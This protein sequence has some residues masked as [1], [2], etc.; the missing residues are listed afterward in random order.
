MS[1]SSLRTVLATALLFTLTAPFVVKAQDRADFPAAMD[2]F[3]RRAMERTEAVPGLA[4]AVVDGAGPIHVAGFGV[5][6]VGTGA[7]VTADTRFYIAS[8][9]KSF[10]ALAVSA[11]AARGQ[12]DLDAPVATWS[13]GSGVPTEI[14]GRTTLSD[15]LSHRS[16]VENGPIAFRTAYSGDWTPEILWR[17]T[18]ETAPGEVP[19]GTFD[20][21]NSGYNL[22]TILIERQWGRDWR[23][24]VRD[25][26]LTPLGMSRTTALV[27][28]ARAQGETVAAGH[29]GRVPGR[30][31]RSYLQ[32]ID[33]T[34]QSAGGL[35]STASDM[36]I[37]LEAQIS[38]GRIDGR[39]RLP[40]G[41]VV[42][43]HAS[44]VP[45]DTTFGPYQRTGYGL[46]W[47]V[48]RY[49]D[50]LLIH[51]FGNF[52]GSRA[53]VSFMPERGIGVAVMVNEDV[54]AGDL[55]DVVASYAYDWFAGLPDI[56]AVYDA[57]LAELAETRDRRR[58]G[59]ARSLEARAARPRTL[60]LPNAAYVGDYVSPAYGTLTVREAGDRLEVAIGIQ[61]AIA[62]NFT[63][64]E[65]LRVELTPF[66]GEAVAF[67]LDADGRPASLKYNGETF[68]RPAHRP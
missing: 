54:F 25:E 14:A 23:A 29:F 11:M 45:Q 36:A 33:T 18:A 22:A 64:P 39:Q 28:E 21:T 56:E 59:L 12:V 32:K 17:L 10:T 51:H 68:A 55:A 2:A 16:G 40:P 61:R 38:D 9:T 8:A 50:D 42:S 57:K 20:Y 31:E 67:T 62:E 41:L 52:A 30:P 27:D 49:G 65:S 34:M 48:G 7:V 63:D 4:V 35:I 5:A 1:P 58:A 13:E 66:V 60:S 47:Q 44:K 43:T 53:H 19:P 26:V 6:D 3:V 24:L 15:L 37:W 46:G